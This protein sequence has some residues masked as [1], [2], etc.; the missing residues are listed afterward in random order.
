MRQEK[1]SPKFYLATGTI[2]TWHKEC[3]CNLYETA[4]SNELP[5]EYSEDNHAKRSAQ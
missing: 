2:E 4:Y 5:V 1:E 3:N